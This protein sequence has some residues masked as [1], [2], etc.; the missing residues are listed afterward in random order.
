MIDPI[1]IRAR[2]LC[3]EH[4]QG[5]QSSPELIERALRGDYDTGS[6]VTRW[7]PQA[8]AEALRNRAEAEGE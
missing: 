7:I 8:E 3:A 2:E 4:L 6:Y 5:R 1:L